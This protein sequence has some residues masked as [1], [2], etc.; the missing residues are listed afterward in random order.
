MMLG[1]LILRARVPLLLTI[2][3]LLCFCVPGL[4]RLEVT[5]DI[6]DYLL[7]DDP[8]LKADQD[9]R[10]LFPPQDFVGVLVENDDVFSRESL[11]LIWQIG[12]TL[13]ESVP[14]GDRA[15]SVASVSGT[16]T[17]GR[18]LLFKGLIMT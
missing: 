3:A 2:L 12:R 18:A 16:L 4:F 15:V 13:Q 9:F 8:I 6:R 14:Q 5:V 7:E 10:R 11:E 1:R 17:G